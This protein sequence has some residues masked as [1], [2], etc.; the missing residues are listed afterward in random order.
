MGTI[1]I[2]QNPLVPRVTV[3][4]NTILAN[5]DVRANAAGKV[6]IRGGQMVMGNAKIESQT[7]NGDSHEINIG[8]KNDLNINGIPEVL[9]VESTQQTSIFTSTLGTGKA[10]NIVLDVDG[11]LKLTHGAQILSISGSSGDGGDIKI[12]ANTIRLEGNRLKLAQGLSTATVL[13]TGNAGNIAISVVDRLDLSGGT[14]ITSTTSSKGN[15][16]ALTIKTNSLNINEST[17]SVITFGNGNGG[18]INITAADTISLTGPSG[19]ILNHTTGSGNSGKIT[20]NSDKLDVRNGILI[21]S[22]TN[23]TGNSGDLF[24]HSNEVVLTNDTLSLVMSPNGSIGIRPTGITAQI[25]ETR[26]D[27]PATG[28]SGNLVVKADNLTVSNGAEISTSNLGQGNSGDLL[29]DSNNILLTTDLD[30]QPFRP[31]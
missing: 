10:S 31:L 30:L 16:G 14:L 26:E 7:I 23:N 5:I 12:S 13:G 1:N 28:N 17:A 9:G 27:R 29:V 21:S 8:L 3:G 18:D 11:L 15:A 22:T 4:Q 19:G 6:F 24:I 20:I 25:I 2:S